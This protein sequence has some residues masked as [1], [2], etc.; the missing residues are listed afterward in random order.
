MSTADAETRAQHLL[1]LTALAAPPAATAWFERTVRRVVSS[2]A[3][4]QVVLSS[5]ARQVLRLRLQEKVLDVPAV[6]RHPRLLSELM[7][8]SG[9]YVQP[10]EQGDPA[11]LD[12]SDAL[13]GPERAQD[14]ATLDVTPGLAQPDRVQLW[15]SLRQAWQAACQDQVLPGSGIGGQ[16]HE[17]ALA[18]AFD[19]CFLTA[20]SG[21]EGKPATTA[22]LTA[23]VK[24]AVSAL[25]AGQTDAAL[26]HCVEW[27]R[28]LKVAA[29]RW[30][31]LLASY[32][33]VRP[34]LE[35]ACVVPLQA[36]ATAL[37]YYVRIQLSQTIR[38]LERYGHIQSGELSPVALAAQLAEG[39]VEAQSAGSSDSEDSS[40]GG[41]DE[42]GMD[43]VL[44]LSLEQ[45]HGKGNIPSRVDTLLLPVD[46]W[47]YLPALAGVDEA[48]LPSLV[49]P[50]VQ[51]V[52]SRVKAGHVRVPAP[53]AQEDHDLEAGQVVALAS[54]ADANH[55]ACTEGV[56]RIRAASG[57]P[58]EDLLRLQ[59][60]VKMRQAGEVDRLVAGLRTHC[61]AAEVAAL[62]SLFLVFKALCRHRQLAAE[63]GRDHAEATGQQWDT[64][65]D[66][67][68]ALT[69]P[70]FLF[71][72]GLDELWFLGQAASLLPRAFPAL[73]EPLRRCVAAL[74]LED[75]DSALAG[76]EGEPGTG[77][78]HTLQPLGV[79]CPAYSGPGQGHVPRALAATAFN[80]VSYD[81]HAVCETNAALGAVLQEV[82]RCRACA[83][84]DAG[85]PED[86]VQDLAAAI[87]GLQAPRQGGVWGSLPLWAA[88]QHLWG[89]PE[90]VAA[91]VARTLTDMQFK[92][93]LRAVSSAEARGN[94]TSAAKSQLVWAFTAR[95][96]AVRS[97]LPAHQAFGSAALMLDAP[98]ATSQAGITTDMLRRA[99][100]QWKAALEGGQEG[101]AVGAEEEGEDDPLVDLPQAARS[102]MPG[103]LP[104]ASLVH[105]SLQEGSE[106]EAA[107]P[108]DLDVG[109]QPA[110]L[111]LGGLQGPWAG[112]QSGTDSGDE[113][114]EEGGG[115][116][117]KPSRRRGRGEG[118]AV[119]V[120]LRFRAAFDYSDAGVAAAGAQGSWDWDREG[121][122]VF[123][124]N[125]PITATAEDVSEALSRCGDVQAVH[126]MDQ[127]AQR[128]RSVLRARFREYFKRSHKRVQDRLSK[129]VESAQEETGLG[130]GLLDEDA[131]LADDV[132]G[133]EGGHEDIGTLL[134][135]LQRSEAG[136]R[137]VQTLARAGS[138][139]DMK[140][141]EAHP[142]H[143]FVTFRES[144]HA[145][146]A[147]SSA[148]RLFG[149]VI[150][151]SAC[152][153][154]PA[155]DARIVH[156][157]G[158]PNE[159][160]P[161]LTALL[162]RQLLG[163]AGAGYDL[164]LLDA[165]RLSGHMV[166]NG[167]VLLH[168]PSHKDAA[169]L[170]AALHGASLPGG[171]QLSAG[172]GTPAEWRST[173]PRM[174][175]F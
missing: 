8:M 33:G 94:S 70:S 86:Q 138:S 27:S 56:L 28:E 147:A 96:A 58:P 21:G 148:L 93:L 173:R 158:M 40:G 139:A 34:L 57:P 125:L 54:L 25:Q 52:L 76:A 77:L 39:G 90:A 155:A 142:M 9:R 140:L 37:R 151:D 53:G 64:Q 106:H 59:V 31:P 146:T 82:H 55:A 30:V 134:G 1:R 91:L 133:V 164:T 68:S 131:A 130:L 89:Q 80:D 99:R 24:G 42:V 10:L 156:L 95:S 162:L 7:W 166:S 6:R 145:T 92:K 105:T 135:V 69:G 128:L 22:A 48:L 104:D 75:L 60:A 175:S 117:A 161:E 46:A 84:A 62:R 103:M 71:G 79:P 172:W 51:E 87:A 144:A 141:Y 67:G 111:E 157:S 74:A 120:P 167:T 168:M 101:T 165:R 109:L 127:R 19:S 108:L 2:S 113:H 123:V 43:R 170:V 174:P 15:S 5:M 50:A 88:Q 118:P 49:P 115:A 150:R 32:V 12:A 122:T 100:A 3:G 29:P 154:V 18:A 143:A 81:P 66:A 63:A 159:L 129:A 20:M 152:K 83:P 41:A 163:L 65:H 119:H 78:P 36:A 136:G 38:T 112:E 116:K 97:L 44:Q 107:A 45:L 160:V 124:S 121:R 171:R 4:T 149:V 23:A 132:A 14:Q 11:P 47:T 72:T 16:E 98:W 153:V 102:G 73:Y 126:V 17:A 110:A 61:S 169:M 26:K 13:L 35:R 114:S 85:V 137:S